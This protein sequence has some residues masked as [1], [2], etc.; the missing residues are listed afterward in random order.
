MPPELS[1]IL[2]AYDEEEALPRSLPPIIE[3]L[4]K[5]PN[6]WEMIL[7]N[8]G[9]EDTT[10]AVMENFSN[11]HSGL[12]IVD[13][14]ANR[15]YG[16]GVRQGLKTASGRFTAY[17][18]ADG[19]FD[20]AV[21]AP[22]LVMMRENRS[23]FMIASRVNRHDG[24]SRKIISLFF[25][26]LMQ[27]LYGLRV[28]DLNGEPKMFTRETGRELDPESDG[29]FLDTELALKAHAKGLRIHEIPMASPARQGGRSKVRF[30]WT[31]IFLKN[32]LLYR[33]TGR[34]SDRA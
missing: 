4:R 6:P 25:N 12:R 22:M 15:G 24:A 20:P 5:L 30:S 8:N 18:P 29:S 17:A 27:T 19:Q 34:S 31:F 3:A 13:V 23:D 28:N 1:L 21:L 10:R 11:K 26:L 7:V 32:I 9:S 33:L 14:S 2:T 16:Y